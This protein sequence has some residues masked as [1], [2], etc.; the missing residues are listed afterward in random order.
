MQE[1]SKNDIEIIKKEC[2]KKI[3]TGPTEKLSKSQL[4]FYKESMNIIEIG[5][6]I[7]TLSKEKLSAYA[8][9]VQ[10]MV[11][12]VKFGL[13]EN[14]PKESDVDYCFKS[15]K[16]FEWSGLVHLICVVVCLIVGLFKNY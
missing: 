2:S 10:S 12:G 5:K 6:K 16:Y 3:P 9:R 14:E 13:D 4:T 15:C 11:I 1:L 7:D 8:D